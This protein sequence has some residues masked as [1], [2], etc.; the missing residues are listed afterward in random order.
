M[1]SVA[2]TTPS[3]PVWVPETVAV[4]SPSSTSSSTGVKVKVAVPRVCPWAIVRLNAL[5]AWKSSPAVA[6]A[7]ATA[8]CTTVAVPRGAPSSAPVTVTGVGLAFSP[9]VACH[10]ERKVDP[11]TA[12]A[13]LRRELNLPWPDRD[14]LGLAGAA[15]T[16]W[17]AAQKR[18]PRD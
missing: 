10:A 16:A 9:T 5:T 11:A 2:A 6:V 18:R 4:S 13:A 7:P 17:R 1:V 12:E 15:V 8:S 3:P 14:S